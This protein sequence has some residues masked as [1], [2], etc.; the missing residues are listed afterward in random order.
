MRS[1]L[2]C[3]A[4][5][6]AAAIGAGKDGLAAP[7]GRPVI[8]APGPGRLSN[9]DEQRF[10]RLMVEHRTTRMRLTREERDDLDRLSARVR[11]VLFP[12]G[13]APK[14][15]AWDDAKTAVHRTVPGL[16]D[17]EAGALAAYAVDAI[18][19]GDLEII[20]YA[21]TSPE[22]GTLQ[23]FKRQY[24]T[25][26]SEMQNENRSYMAVSNIMKTKHDTVKNSISNVR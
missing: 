13:G 10:D 21:K 24:M 9:A 5:L 15:S 19:A 20:R 17:S 4:V 23:A 25:L 3:C 7:A 26:Q 16:S 1:K 6:A 11:D 8:G 22:F 14:A 18:A 12:D 2:L